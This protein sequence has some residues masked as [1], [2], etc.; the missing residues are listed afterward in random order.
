MSCLICMILCHD[1]FAYDTSVATNTAQTKP[2]DSFLSLTP[3]APDDSLPFKL[4]GIGLPGP[5]YSKWFSWFLMFILYSKQMHFLPVFFH[6][7]SGAYP[8]VLLSQAF[9]SSLV[10]FGCPSQPVLS[11]FPYLCSPCSGQ[12]AALEDSP[13]AILP[14]MFPVWAVLQHTSP[15]LP[16]LSG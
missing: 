14:P 6:L 8:D 11:S 5:S 4:S 9:V 15:T 7:Q 16:R 13:V 1:S 12:S 3:L 10:R 2:L